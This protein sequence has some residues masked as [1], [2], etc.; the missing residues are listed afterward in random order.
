MLKSK[1]SYSS[2]V[3]KTARDEMFDYVN[4]ITDKM[5]LAIMKKA[6]KRDALDVLIRP[7]QKSSWIVAMII[8]VVLAICGHGMPLFESNVIRY[9]NYLFMYI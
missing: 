1:L 6:I 5:V 8:F 2:Y 4:V 7:F 9:L 3:W